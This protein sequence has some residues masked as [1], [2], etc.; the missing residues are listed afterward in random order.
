MTAFRI[1]IEFEPELVTSAMREQGLSKSWF[2]P[3]N[4]TTDIGTLAGELLKHFDVDVPAPTELQLTTGGFTLPHSSGMKVLRDGDVVTVSGVS[5]NNSLSD[6]NRSDGYNNNRQ[7]TSKNENEKS[8]QGE[9]EGSDVNE[10]PQSLKGKSSDKKLLQES[11]SIRVRGSS[12]GVKAVS[13]NKRQAPPT[14][15]YFDGKRMRYPPSQVDAEKPCL[16]CKAKFKQEFLHVGAH[17]LWG[18]VSTT[19]CGFCGSEESGC[20]SHLKKVSKGVLRPVS[21]C[22]YFFKFS[23]KALHKVDRR[24]ARCTNA[25]LECS[26]CPPGPGSFVWK[27]DMCTHWNAHHRDVLADSTNAKVPADYLV[28]PDEVFEVRRRLKRNPVGEA[29]EPIP[30]NLF[31]SKRPGVPGADDDV[32]AAGRAVELGSLCFPMG[33]LSTPMAMGPTDVQAY[34]MMTSSGLTPVGGDM[35]PSAA[36]AMAVSKMT[37]GVGGHGAMLLKQVKHL[38]TVDKSSK[39]LQNASRAGALANQTDPDMSGE[40][41]SAFSFNM[42]NSMNFSCGMRSAPMNSLSQPSLAMSQIMNTPQP[43]GADGMKLE[44]DAVSIGLTQTPPRTPSPFLAR[45]NSNPMMPPASAGLPFSGE[46]A[47][48]HGQG[49]MLNHQLQ[50]MQDQAMQQH[51]HDQQQMQMQG[52]HMHMQ[53][54]A[55][56]AM[57]E[58]QQQMQEHMQQQVLGHQQQQQQKVQQM[59]KH[60]QQQMQDQHHMHDLEFMDPPIIPMSVPSPAPSLQSNGIMGALLTSAADPSLRPPTSYRPAT[61]HARSAS[62]GTHPSMH[63]MDSVGLQPILSGPTITTQALPVVTTSTDPVADVLGAM[64]AGPP[65]SL[66]HGSMIGV[67]CCLPMQEHMFKDLPL[68]HSSWPATSVS[69]FSHPPQPS[70]SSM[71]MPPVASGG[72]HVGS[73]HIRH[74]GSR[75]IRP[76]GRE[77]LSRSSLVRS[78]CAFERPLNAE[79]DG[80]HLGRTVD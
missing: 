38:H 50:Q 44:G 14:E 36:A 75:H 51:I 65:V 78:A 45:E 72:S 25:P 68:S 5:K 59:T 8:V 47:A 79:G 77:I 57:N 41:P 34:D 33:N 70:L 49:M 17:M 40:Y 19:A 42:G 11:R 13:G 31:M 53:Y 10:E 69:P 4:S 18:D 30:P 52:Q 9:E 39:K 80:G 71:P 56:L 3:L 63:S 58:Q 28:M 24:M 67:P 22:P 48:S 62:I 29:S 26:A 15:P 32:S 35:S 7:D 46:M 76:G 55:H 23:H 54:D 66:P 74:V 27:Y 1:R 43:M 12:S 37:G 21:T 2:T 60:V 61:S 73:R 6:A 16:V 64:N 20:H